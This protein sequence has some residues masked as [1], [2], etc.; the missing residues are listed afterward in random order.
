MR[1]QLRLRRLDR[2]HGVFRDEL[3][4]LAKA[5]PDDGVVLVEAQRAGFAVQD[6]L[7]HRVFDQRV[8]FRRIRRAL[9][10]P[11]EPRGQLLDAAARNHD[12]PVR[13]RVRQPGVRAEERAA[14]QEEMQQRLAQQGA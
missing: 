9:P 4:L 2:R 5:A 7:A 1:L 3:E 10:N 6:F 11:G 12:L 8:E 13:R 14:Q